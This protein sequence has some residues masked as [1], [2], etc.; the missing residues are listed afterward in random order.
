M[1]SLF[2]YFAAY[3]CL[4]SVSAQSL[5]GRRAPKKSVNRSRAQRTLMLIGKKEQ[6]LTY[7]LEVTIAQEKG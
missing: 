1:R 6:E 4:V 3:S 2:V 7:A 5:H